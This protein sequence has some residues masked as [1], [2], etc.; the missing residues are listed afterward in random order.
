MKLISTKTIIFDLMLVLVIFMI[1]GEISF[2]L[3]GSTQTI[4]YAYDDE[5]GVAYRPRQTAVS[6]LGNFSVQSPP[7]TINEQGYRGA[8]AD[9]TRPSI[10]ICG[11]SEVFGPG[12]S[13]NEVFSSQLES[14]LDAKGYRHQVLN[15][16][17]G[18]YGPYHHAVTANRYVRALAPSHVVV[19]VSSGDRFFKRPTESQLDNLR[20][21]R[22]R[23]DRIGK[24][25]AFVPFLYNK[26]RAQSTAIK[27]TYDSL[28][29][30][31]DDELKEQTSVFATSEA[32]G[33]AMWDANNE[34]WLKLIADSVNHNFEL[35]FLVVNPRSL[36]A[37][38]Y[39]ARQLA[40]TAKEYTNVTVLELDS[41]RYSSTAENKTLSAEWYSREYTL[42]YDPHSNAR[43]HALIAE[44]IFD[45]L[46]KTRKL[47]SNDDS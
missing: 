29:D 27:A 37:D 4:R 24:R 11:S 5:L 46:L 30:F 21:L 41:R 17:V 7:I 39:I 23:N 31:S 34:Y 33:I 13:D 40:L 10:L 25:T 6:F 22:E 26:M 20:R 44:N 32:A 1:I 45:T 8:T 36:A 28:F 35:I 43:H 18:G 9:I 15:L 14:L 47:N 16:G 38:E 42:G 3:P 19:R 2:R 12:I